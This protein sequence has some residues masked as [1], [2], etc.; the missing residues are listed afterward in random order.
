MALYLSFFS[1]SFPY[2]SAILNFGCE[3]RHTN[4]KLVLSDAQMPNVRA[5]CHLCERYHLWRAR[6]CDAAAS[7]RRCSVI[8]NSICDA[9]GEHAIN[10]YKWEFNGSVRF[11]LSSRSLNASVFIQCSTGPYDA[12]KPIIFNGRTSARIVQMETR[13]F[14]CCHIHAFPWYIGDT[15]M[16]R[17]YVQKNADLMDFHRGWWNEFFQG[18]ETVLRNVSQYWP[19]V[20]NCYT[21]EMR[22][23]KTT[24]DWHCTLTLVATALLRLQKNLCTCNCR[25]KYIE[26][27]ISMHRETLDKC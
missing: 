16:C 21:G 3:R 26:R 10:I 4:T 9:L 12:T 18:R 24:I 1:L 20:K 23:L 17:R 27:Y 25:T 7:N 15:G 14:G 19:I 8:D 5:H 22:A 6:N 13:A 2:L 11:F